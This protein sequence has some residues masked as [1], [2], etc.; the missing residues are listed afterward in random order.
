VLVEKLDRDLAA[1]GG[2]LA[3]V[4]GAHAALAEPLHHLERADERAQQGVLSRRRRRDVRVLE[5]RGQR[6]A[7]ADRRRPH[8][9]QTGAHDLGTAREPTVTNHRRARL[10]GRVIA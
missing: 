3:Q 2:V 10:G 4:D 7:G 9:S 1:D 5:H 6:L 8:R